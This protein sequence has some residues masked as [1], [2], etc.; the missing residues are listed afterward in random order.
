[1]E[2][3]WYLAPMSVV[4]L[5]AFIFGCI[6][7]SLLP[8]KVSGTLLRRIGHLGLFIALFLVVGSIFNGF[9]SCWVWG[10]LYDSTDYVFDF[11]PFWP[12]TQRVI[13]APWGD[14]H[15]HLRGISL[16]Q[17]QLIWLSFAVSTWAVTILLFRFLSRK[18][19]PRIGNMASQIS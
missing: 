17:L 5:A 14:D 4:H 18:S 1:M 12:I 15:G 7:L 2:C 19:P 8:R 10:R 9:W 16:F 13:D 11:M 6:V 3:L